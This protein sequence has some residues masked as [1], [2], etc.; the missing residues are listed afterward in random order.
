MPKS[1]TRAPWLLTLGQDDALAV[2]AYAP[3]RDGT[4]LWDRAGLIEVGVEIALEVREA[5]EL[6]SQ[7]GSN[8]RLAPRAA[9]SRLQRPEAPTR[10]GRRKGTPIATRP[11]GGWRDVGYPARDRSRA[12]ADYCGGSVCCLRASR[13]W[14]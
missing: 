14:A 11:R 6:V 7:L 9:G 8:Q 1:A 3:P 12:S 13:T 10:P 4:P 5:C 2:L